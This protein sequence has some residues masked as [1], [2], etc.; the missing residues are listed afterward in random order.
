MCMSFKEKYASKISRPAL[1]FSL[2]RNGCRASSSKVIDVLEAREE[3]G[4]TIA[5][6]LSS[7][8]GRK[9]ISGCSD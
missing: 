9:M 7:I 8:K 5:Q 3:S 6:S 1:P 4:G 2:M